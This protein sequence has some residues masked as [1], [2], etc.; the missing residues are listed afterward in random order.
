MTTLPLTPQPFAPTPNTSSPSYTSFPRSQVPGPPTQGPVSL[1][2]RAPRTS[3]NPC[4]VSSSP[5]T[6][7][8][9]PQLTQL[10]ALVAL[11]LWLHGPRSS[12]LGVP[13]PGSHLVVGLQLIPDGDAPATIPCSLQGPT[14]THSGGLCT[15]ILPPQG[16]CITCAGEPK[17]PSLCSQ[18]PQQ[19]P[20]VRSPSRGIPEAQHGDLGTRGRD[21]PVA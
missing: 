5:P 12:C 10:W 8:G 1:S 20:F 19:V 6:L 4:R 7:L 18:L 11:S 16:P 17:P 21:E 13:G 3:G 14:G 2:P 9:G 15:T